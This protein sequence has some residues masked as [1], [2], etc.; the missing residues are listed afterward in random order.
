MQQL[1]KL[2]DWVRSD[3]GDG[4]IEDIPLTMPDVRMTDGRLLSFHAEDLK[5][6]KPSE[7]IVKITLE[8][9]I[10]THSDGDSRFEFDNINSTHTN[11]IN[12]IDLKPETRQL[13][14]RLLKAQEE[15]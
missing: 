12:F 3:E 8:G 14:E 15:K 1:L 5:L 13:V 4:V 7:V 9:T 2:G 11:L 10:E 6:I